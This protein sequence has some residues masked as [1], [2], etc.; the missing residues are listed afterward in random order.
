[1]PSAAFAIA[2]TASSLSSEEAF[3]SSVNF[4]TQT[5]PPLEQQSHTRPWAPY[6]RSS[7]AN[8]HLFGFATLF[9]WA[10]FSASDESKILTRC[11]LFETKVTSAFQDHQKDRCM[12]AFW[13]WTF[14]DEYTFPHPHHHHRCMVLVRRDARARLRHQSL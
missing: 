12:V 7:I 3:P 8:S 2:L 6:P 10:P 13:P 5:A 1:M 4:N 9:H 14:S 11:F